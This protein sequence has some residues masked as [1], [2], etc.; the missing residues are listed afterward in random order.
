LRLCGENGVYGRALISIGMSHMDSS[1]GTGVT[2]KLLRLLLPGLI[3]AG[4]ITPCQALEPEPRKW[5]HLPTGTNFAGVGYAHTEADISFDPT[6]LLEDAKMDM[7]SRVG[8]YIRTF[9]GIDR[10]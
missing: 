7:D 10:F 5:N 8:Q 2:G 6:L 9:A 4:I 1:S 3:F